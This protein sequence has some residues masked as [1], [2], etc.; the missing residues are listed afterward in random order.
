MI[1]FNKLKKMTVY[2][3]TAKYH[4]AWWKTQIIPI[5]FN[6]VT[7]INFLKKAACSEKSFLNVFI[8][9]KFKFKS[10]KLM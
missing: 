10:F 6:T 7:C 8:S 1:K 5:I 9:F 3:Q 2:R 4:K